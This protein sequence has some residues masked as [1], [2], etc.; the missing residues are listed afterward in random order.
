MSF[1]PKALR[2]SLRALAVAAAWLVVGPASADSAIEPFDA[3]MPRPELGRSAPVLRIA[4]LS[5]AQCRAELARRKLPVKRAGRAAPGVATP[6]RLTGPVGGVRFIAPGGK[7]PYGI[8]DCRMVLTLELFAQVLVKH[9]VV[10]VRVDNAYRPHARLP[11]RRKPSQHSYGLAL[12]LMS[13]TLK[14]GRVLDVERDFGR[15]LGEPPCGPESRVAENAESTR[16]LR[17]LVCDVARRGLFHYMLTP[18]YNEAHR[19][20]LHFDIKRGLQKWLIQ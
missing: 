4:N 14:D 9:D 2:A 11:G 18:N 6:L 16:A 1:L 8:L 15:V 3:P 13:F 10:A 5:P 12:D 7:S 17:N 20:H 19:N